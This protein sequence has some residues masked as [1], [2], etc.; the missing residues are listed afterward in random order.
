MLEQKSVIDQELLKNDLRSLDPKQFYFK[1]IIK[2]Q[3]W[4]FEEY[5]KIPTCDLI[6]RM[7]Y[8]KE[9]V[10]TGLKISFHSLQI[11]GS[12]K[13][14]YSLSPHKLLIPFHDGSGPL[15]PSS[16]IDIAIVSE[17][18]YQKFWDRLRNVKGLWNKY[19]YDQLTRSI[20]RG[21]I[22]DKD[23]MRINDV[24]EEWTELT[25]PINV[26]LQDNL[27]FV[28]P[29]SYRLYRYWDDLEDYQLYSISKAKKKL[30][31]E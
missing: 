27:G 6:D 1:H 31:E 25:S 9:I 7:D 22:N 19:Y 18:L 24:R 10:S 13:T 4:Y 17:R 11:V 23:L 12:A 21:Y 15:E 8:F 29:I 30:E 28:H 2:S 26:S 20:F 14:G 3:N 5:L 16:D